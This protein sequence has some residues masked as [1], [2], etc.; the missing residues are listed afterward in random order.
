MVHLQ[1]SRGTFLLSVVHLAMQGRSP[2]VVRILDSWWLRDIIPQDVVRAHHDRGVHAERGGVRAAR[3]RVTIAMGA[4]AP[5]LMEPQRNLALFFNHTQG[6]RRR[7]WLSN[8]KGRQDRH[9]RKDPI[10]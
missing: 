10:R 2:P 7:R 4:H 1:T 9:E 5:A 8:R 3:C 6:E